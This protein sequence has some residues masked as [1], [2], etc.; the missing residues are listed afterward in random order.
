MTLGEAKPGD[1]YLVD[2]D[3]LRCRIAPSL[4]ARVQTTVSRGRELAELARRG[5]WMRVTIER[6]QAQ[7]ICGW[8]YGRYVVAT[9]GAES[10]PIGPIPDADLPR[11][12]P[13]AVDAK[14]PF[15]DF[16]DAYRKLARRY[17]QEA[18]HDLFRNV[19]DGGDGLLRLTATRHWTNLT[20][21][22]RQVDLFAIL[23]MWKLAN[24][25]YPVTVH[26]IDS[27]GN[28]LMTAYE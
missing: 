5:S 20:E 7:V 23:K 16:M 10:P 4:D 25:D 22:D 17:R 9:N 21:G 2:V 27:R 26:V 14:Q 15:R 8:V 11:G 6:D 12:G 13:P 3:G 1:R 24:N 28:I 19:S 18:G